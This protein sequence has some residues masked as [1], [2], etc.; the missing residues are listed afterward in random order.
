MQEYAKIWKSFPKY[1]KVYNIVQ[2]YAKVSENYQNS[3]RK[4]SKI[5]QKV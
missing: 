3:I 2:K 4:V 5:M 1:A